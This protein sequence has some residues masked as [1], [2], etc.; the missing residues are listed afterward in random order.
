MT[1]YLKTLVACLALGV[2][3]MLSD[4]AVKAQAP[5]EIAEAPIPADWQAHDLR[6]YGFATPPGWVE[7]ERSDDLLIMFGGNRETRTGPAF[8]LMLNANPMRTL[9][10]RGRDPSRRGSFC[11]WPEVYRLSRQGHARTR[12]HD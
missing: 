1:H 12:F 2:G 6:G 9:Q 8:G 4:G 3:A 7:A 10:V 5:T 11:Q